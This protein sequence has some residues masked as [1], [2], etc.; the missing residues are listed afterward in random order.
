MLNFVLNLLEK[1]PFPA[2][3]PEKRKSPFPAGVP[4]D[5]FAIRGLVRTPGNGP[6]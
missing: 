6:F 2:G 1:D 4:Q 3:V 5:R